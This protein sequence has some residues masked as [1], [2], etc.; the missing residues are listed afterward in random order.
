MPEI[1]KA[2]PEVR[3][4]IAGE[5]YGDSAVYLNQIRHLGIANH[6]ETHLRYIA[7]SEI[8][9]LFSETDL[10]VLPYKSASQSG[11]IATSY[12]YLVPVLA[13]ETGGLGEYVFEGKTGYLVPPNSPTELAKAAIRHLQEKPEMK[14]AIADFTA[15]LSWH[16][17][18]EL[19][20]T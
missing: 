6:V 20:I 14:Q 7:S 18:A 16:K 15:K 17:L 13:T 2:I 3:L 10:C 1:I 5:V 8:A 19:V 12:S 11:V 4:I 9:A